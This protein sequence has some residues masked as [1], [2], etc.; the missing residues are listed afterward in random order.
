M[1]NLTMRS[2]LSFLLIVTWLMLSAC[3]DAPLPRPRT[4]FRIALPDRTYQRFDV[5][6]PYS[7]DYPSY[8]SIAPRTGAFAEPYWADIVMPRFSARIYLSYKPVRGNLA[9]YL[10][11]NHL[12]MS[13]LIPKSTGIKEDEVIDDINRVY[14]TIYNVEGSGV[15]S[16]C[17]FYLTDSVR[18]FLRGALYFNVIPNNDSLAP[19]IQF[20]KGDIRHLASTLQWK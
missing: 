15:A 10:N 11:D 2:K 8:A 17:Q 16:P 13:K 12:M 9:E 18:H 20:I 5:G 7:F 14:G 3:G 4:Y 1:H 6:F 19:V